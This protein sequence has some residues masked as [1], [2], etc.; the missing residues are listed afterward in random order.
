MQKDSNVKLWKR[1]LFTLSDD[2]FFNI[3][4]NYLG[5]VRT[6]YNKH[7]LIDRLCQFI[8]RDDIQQA[9]LDHL[10]SED[11]EL[12]S[13]VEVLSNSTI[14]QL[15]AF[16]ETALSRRMVYARLLN[17]ADRLLLFR[18]PQRHV[19]MV[20]PCLKEGMIARGLGISRLIPVDTR[21]G[22]ELSGT[23]PWFNNALVL[24]TLSLLKDQ[25]EI[26]RSDGSLKKTTVNC[27]TDAFG[28]D[29]SWTVE[30]SRYVISSLFL[31]GLFGIQDQQCTVDLQQCKKWGE[32]SQLQRL[33][34][35]WAAYVIA[36]NREKP[37]DFTRDPLFQINEKLQK[38][39]ESLYIFL[40]RL[41]TGVLYRHIAIIRIIYLEMGSLSIS[42][43]KIIKALK[44]L[45]LII[46]YEEAYFLNPMLFS[47]NQDM[48][49]SSSQVL[50]VQGDYSLILHDRGNFSAGLAIALASRLKQYDRVCRFEIHKEAVFS[51]L[52]I[53]LNRGD[54]LQSMKTLC[55]SIPQNVSFS[56]E[57]WENEYFSVTIRPGYVLSAGETTAAL[58][59]HIHDELP[60]VED[61]GNGHFIF[62]A[63]NLH[64]LDILE[65]R[66]ISV[67]QLFRQHDRINTILPPVMLFNERQVSPLS[68]QSDWSTAGKNRISARMEELEQQVEKL[69]L[70]E[71]LEKEIKLRIRS[72]LILAPEQIDTGIL[73]PD[74]TEAR[75]L[76][77]NAKLRLIEAAISAG[78]LLELAV[79]N[80]QE[81]V[82]LK[83]VRI[84]KKTGRD[85]LEA[86]CLPEEDDFDIHISKIRYIRRLKNSLFNHL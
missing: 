8:Q 71:D 13:A 5:S 44:E 46:Q 84:I 33:V 21:K 7:D 79:T 29:P 6:P 60:T 75:G 49:D 86:L 26:V 35:Q 54:I 12:L 59:R 42:G 2:I 55:E 63:D 68:L 82:L 65:S 74:I 61:L 57:S 81:M 14:E 62:P 56:I 9:I 11:M 28:T 53:G 19:F 22:L 18:H 58:I 30:R 78:N 41:E 24:A 20:N 73:R 67:K 10:S 32:M 50:S 43:E 47:L 17:L 38:L 36:E 27:F 51:G 37:E 23:A 52:A 66:G 76:D 1:F 4:R 16:F 69:Q 25:R 3:I 48:E 72:G 34:Y 45:N 39:A 40:Q 77:Y 31:C 80:S 70:S 64:W 15:Y 85:S 83:P